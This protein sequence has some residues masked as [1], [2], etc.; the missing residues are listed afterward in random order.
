MEQY[1]VRQQQI[2]WDKDRVHPLGRNVNHDSRSRYFAFVAPKAIDLKTVIHQRNIPILNQGALGSCT[3]NATVGALGTTPMFESL[4]RTLSLDEA[5]AVAIYSDATAIDPFRGQYPPDDTGS[6]GLSVAKVAQ[7]RGLISGYQHAFDLNS[8]L[9]ALMVGPVIT[10]TNWYSS[11]DYPATGGLVT[12]SSGAQVEGGHEFCVYGIDVENKEVLAANSWGQRWGN[13]GTFRM[14]W[15]TWG[16][17]LSE[18]GDVTIFVPLTQAPPNPSPTPVQSAD[19]IFATKAKKFLA[20]NPWFY[21]KT[22]QQYA[23]DWLKAKGYA[24]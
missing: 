13:A 8:A 7:K 14:S 15:D 5:L 20:G 18:Q 6:D 23:K 12:I 16:R 21:R 1:T 24:S 9:A 10:G 19:D 3:G 17:L 11:F 22:M 4:P 2:E